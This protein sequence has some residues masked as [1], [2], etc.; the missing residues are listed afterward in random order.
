MLS[1][2]MPERTV[3]VVNLAIVALSSKGARV[4]VEDVCDRYRPDLV[5]IYS[6][7][8]EFMEV[9]AERLAAVDATFWSRMADD[10]R[11]LNLSRWLV[12]LVHGGPHTPSLAT[13]GDTSDVRNA[14]RHAI[15]KIELTDADVAQTVDAYASNLDHMVTAAQDHDVDIALMTVP[16]NW[17]WR[18]L[19]DLD[20]GWLGEL[21]GAPGTCTQAEWARAIE[22]LDAHVAE[23]APLARHDWL[24]KRAVAHERM[25]QLESARADYRAAL[26]AD[27]TRRRALDVANE[28][29]REIAARRGVPLVDAVEFLAARTENGILGFE[30][31]YD[32][33]HLTPR[34][35]VLLAGEVM[36]VL[37]EQGRV[38]SDGATATEAYVIAQVCRF[39]KLQID[40]LA[41]DVW[42]GLGF[43]VRAR[44][45]N[46]DL[47][48]YDRLL[49]ELDE[50]IAADPD[51]AIA[52][53]YRGNFHFFRVGE[54]DDAER[55]YR[56]AL[57]LL[58]EQADVA[59]NLEMLR[60]RGRQ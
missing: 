18:G 23:S 1:A 14:L 25:G 11:D 31:F 51:D 17:R 5:V 59:R 48:K 30:T 45:A 37:Q 44:M 36:R 12:R 55:D 7:N 29:V 56:R 19:E 3:E 9:H 57:E 46:R 47:W 21:F 26:N 27:P 43:D 8:N 39:E 34:S 50:R 10:V 15:E 52:H 33:V 35:A 49:S 38:P 32:N 58:G 2:R 42:L 6:G 41:A 22:L 24:F 54:E 16:S 53:V 40:P 60:A 20:D 4:L 13:Q 28:R